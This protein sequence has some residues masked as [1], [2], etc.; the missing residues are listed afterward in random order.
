MEITTPDP[1]TYSALLDLEVERLPRTERT[2]SAGLFEPSQIWE[3]RH[4]RT[5]LVDGD[6]AAWGFI[7]RPTFFPP[8]WAILH[9]FVAAAHEGKGVG[10][11]LRAELTSLLPDVVQVLASRVDDLEERSLAVAEHWGYRVEQH[12][13]VSEMALVDLPEPN[14][15]SDLTVEDA[16]DLNF[17]D[18]DAVEAMLVDSQTNPE[19]VQDGIITRLAD[20][21]VELAE[22]GR[23]FALLARVD[24]AP[25]AIITGEIKDEILLIHYTG[26]G[27]A[28]RGRG[29]AFSL[30]QEAHVRAAAAGATRSYTTNEASNTGIR[31]VNAQLGYRIV[32]GDYRIRRPR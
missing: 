6:L 24:G 5:A 12:G 10:T 7:A 2:A 22:A 32:T 26:V 14:L 16:A 13:I 25:A 4:F 31:H 18:E 28:F 3:Y 15:P 8:D 29:L 30:K 27:Q 23:P 9:V 21:R 1:A 17:P 19:A 20:I 11:A